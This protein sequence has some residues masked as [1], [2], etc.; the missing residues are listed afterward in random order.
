M[1]LKRAHRYDPP[2]RGHEYANAIATGWINGRSGDAEGVAFEM[3]QRRELQIVL[4]RPRSRRRWS[5]YR[6]TNAN[7]PAWRPWLHCLTCNRFAQCP[8]VVA[9]DPEAHRHRLRCSICLQFKRDATRCTVVMLSADVPAQAR[10]LPV[11]YGDERDRQTHTAWDLG[12]KSTA[13][14]RTSIRRKREREERALWRKM[15]RTQGVA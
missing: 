10:P 5:W 12:L 4:K 7:R 1:S 8:A 11:R 2:P 14:T 9:R 13:Q 15:D 6:Q 3:D